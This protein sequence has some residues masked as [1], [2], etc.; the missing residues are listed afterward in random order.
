MATTNLQAR[1]VDPGQITLGMSRSMADALERLSEKMKTP[2]DDV[3]TQAVALLMVAVEAQD[4]GQRLCFADDDLNVVG[5][6]VDFGISR[7]KIGIY[8][9][10]EAES[11][12]LDP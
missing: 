3:L 10:P 11:D 7:E 2:V 9:F 5:E 12:R 6:V 1:Q 8:H 4:R